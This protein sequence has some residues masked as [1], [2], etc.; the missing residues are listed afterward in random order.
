MKN[1]A[2][3]NQAAPGSLKKST[4]INVPPFIIPDTKLTKHFHKQI[5]Q[6]IWYY[7][8]NFSFLHSFLGKHTGNQEKSRQVKRING[9]EQGI[10]QLELPK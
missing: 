10:Y 5:N 9:E 6:Q 1:N 4:D 2:R 7:F 3:I 8:Y